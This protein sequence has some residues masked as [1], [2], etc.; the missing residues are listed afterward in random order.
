MN[1][2]CGVL[3]IQPPVLSVGGRGHIMCY[4]RVLPRMSKTQKEIKRGTRKGRL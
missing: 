2:G 1:K 4:K 3:G